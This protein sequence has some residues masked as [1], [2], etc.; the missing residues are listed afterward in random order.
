M[1]AVTYLSSLLSLLVSPQFQTALFAWTSGRGRRRGFW[2]QSHGRSWVVRRERAG[3]PR[4]WNP[5][6]A[7][8]DPAE[9]TRPR[10]SGET[11]EA[12]KKRQRQRCLVGEGRGKTD[13]S[14]AHQEP[15]WELLGV[16]FA[17]RATSHQSI[18]RNCYNFLKWHLKRHIYCRNMHLSMWF[19]TPLRI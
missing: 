10:A 3:L 1:F 17:I 19:N 15:L 6:P 4:Y 8:T 13:L 7:P 5:R 18:R 2:C 16:L 9:E 11:K 14:T 12:Y